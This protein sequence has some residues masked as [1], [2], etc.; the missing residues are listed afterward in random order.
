MDSGVFFD[1][2]VLPESAEFL[3]TANLTDVRA[4]ASFCWAVSSLDDSLEARGAYAQL[5]GSRVR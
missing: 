1:E 2:L 5:S 4:S 3:R